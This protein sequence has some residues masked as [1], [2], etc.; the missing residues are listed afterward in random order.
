M[1]AL[2]CSNSTYTQI[3]TVDGISYENS[4]QVVHYKPCFG[5]ICL[6]SE[7]NKNETCFDYKIRQCC[8][9]NTTLVTTTSVVDFN[10]TSVV[11]N[12]PSFSSTSV[13]DFNET[14]VVTNEPSF[15]STSVVDFNE[16][17]VV[18]NE[19]SFS[20]TSV[21]DWNGTTLVTDDRQT[22]TFENIF[23]ET[24]EIEQTTSDSNFESTT[25]STITNHITNL[26][27]ITV[28]S[29]TTTKSP[30]Y[31]TIKFL[32]DSNIFI[33]K[34]NSSK[35]QISLQFVKNEPDCFHNYRNVI[36]VSMIDYTAKNEQD[37]QSN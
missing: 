36:K 10:E 17:S 3:Q 14:S 19:P 11:T 25:E 37:Y 13:V 1:L 22:S 5:F 6:N 15:S 32:N 31:F 8:P 23:T 30:C 21:V 34:E 2:G 4:G 16:T 7:Q 27:A 33:V 26:T 20:S 35:I 24:F 9:I 18:T 28:I 12:E 29:P